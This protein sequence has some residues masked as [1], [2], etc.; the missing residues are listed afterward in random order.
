MKTIA[1]LSQKGGVGKSTLARLIAVAYA[2]SGHRV[3][4]ADFNV[5][6]KTCVNWV[7]ARMK[8]EHKPEV[9]AEP[10]SSVQIALKQSALY[11][12]MV[13]DTRP[14]SDTESLAI[15]KA[16][17]LVLLPT[18]VTVD[19][20]E[21]QI[22]LARELKLKGIPAGRMRFVITNPPESVK[23]VEEARQLI[24]DRGFMTIPTTLPFRIS[25]QQALDSGLAL[26]EVAIG[27]FR[28]RLQP[29]N[30]RA[31]TQAAE[32]QRALKQTEKAA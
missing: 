18:G 15:A 22:A 3:K 7:T 5:K 20:L 14:D 2:K 11:D 23:I 9:A 29:L 10:F 25:Y 32:I 19:D 16:S 24:V 26:N 28:H 31:D 1:C 6:Q 13:F 30:D 4:I 27:V 8:A 21:P 12:L 17:D